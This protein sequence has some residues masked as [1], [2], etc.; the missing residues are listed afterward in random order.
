MPCFPNNNKKILINRECYTSP[1]KATSLFLISI[2]KSY[3]A[4]TF[5][6]YRYLH[7]KGCTILSYRFFLV[8]ELVTKL[9][10]DNFD[11]MYIIKNMKLLQF[12]KAWVLSRKHLGSSFLYGF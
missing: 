9:N 12:A 11:F 5:L 7:Y 4:N 1:K 6:S 2:I 8:F 3:N 10:A